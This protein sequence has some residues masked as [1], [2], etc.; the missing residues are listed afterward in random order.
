MS[1]AEVIGVISG[2][3]AIVDAT[4]KIYSAANDA[5]GLPEAFRDVALRLPLVSK[6]L[7]TISENNITPDEEWRK[8][9]KPVL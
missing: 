9:M 4:I 2:I 6:T 3:I 5:S 8:A 1:G 7:Q